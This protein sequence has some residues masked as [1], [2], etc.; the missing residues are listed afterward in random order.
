MLCECKLSGSTNKKATI[1]LHSF[2]GTV[3]CGCLYVLKHRNIDLKG[4]F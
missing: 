1:V 4:M 2:M 3:P